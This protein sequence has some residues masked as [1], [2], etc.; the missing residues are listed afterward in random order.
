MTITPSIFVLGASALPMA[1]RIQEAYSGARVFGL[2]GRADAADVTYANFG[3][4]LRQQYRQGSPIIALCAAGI[5]IRTLAALLTEK[6]AEPPVLAI[7]EDGSAVVPLLGGLAGVNEIAKTLANHLGVAPAITTSGELRF[8]TCLLNPPPGYA[9]D[10]EQGKRVVSDLLGGATVQLNEDT[11]WLKN[12]DLPLAARGDRRV[13]VSPYRSEDPHT[14]V[15]HPRVVLACV[16]PDRDISR[17]ALDHALSAARLAPQSLAALIVTGVPQAVPKLALLAQ[18]VGVPLRFVDD[19]GVL[20]PVEWET[21]DLS[22]HVANDSTC[23]DSMGIARG[24]LHVVGLGPGAAGYMAPAVR[25]ALD[26]AQDVLGYETYVKMA[27]PFRGDQCLH[28]SDNREELQRAAHAFEL[29]AQGRRVVMV[30]SGDP[31][32]FAMAAAVL[33]AL[34]ASDD[35]RWHGVALHI[36]PGI[37]AAMAAASCAGAPL[38]HDFC[39][40]SLSDN[41]K[42]WSVIEH[43]LRHASAAD[44]VMAFYNP[45]SKSRPWQLGQALDLIRGYRAP[46]TQVVLGRDI[47]RPAESLKLTTLGE[48]TPDQVDMRTMVIIGSSQTRR[49]SSGKRE[50]VYSPRWYPADSR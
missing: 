28:A 41:L 29:A 46:D 12:A 34:E 17:E 2:Q 48:L 44:L 45:I 42:P 47:G 30:S 37:T 9:V 10:L 22:L 49:F 26:A 31:G 36:V 20:G 23:A 4:A 11:P 7:A 50:W 18:D 43:R 21:Q 25:Q 3:E 38:G 32:V 19:A 40:I 5:V 33:E 35:S 16:A 6:G 15:I 39:L 27:G 13:V 8:G 1:R 24:S 14:L